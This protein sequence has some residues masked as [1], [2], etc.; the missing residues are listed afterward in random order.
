M[1]M[2]Q[3][4][5]SA[6]P[7]HNSLAIAVTGPDAGKF[8]Q[9]QLTCDVL[10]LA[11]GQSQL[12]AYCNIKGKVESLFNLTRA[13][14]NYILS[15]QQELLQPTLQE[16]KKYAV[17]SKVTLDLIE[18]P[19]VHVDEKNEIL[20]KIPAIYA[21]TIGTFF[22]HDIN[23]PQLGAVS[24]SKGCYRGQEIVA[25]M[26]YRGNLKRGLYIFTLPQTKIEPGNDVVSTDGKVVGTIVRYCK[27]MDKILGLAV[28]NDITA[29][30]NHSLNVLCSGSLVELALA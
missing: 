30:A 16:L 4:F 9:G 13:G 17:F 29:V 27:D 5:N 25:R 8:L 12:G 11:D 22:P 10:A 18:Q 15:M 7:S 26:E 19:Y 20:N 3:Q 28:I 14:D 1:I 23:L 6:F 2:I 24:F 21:A